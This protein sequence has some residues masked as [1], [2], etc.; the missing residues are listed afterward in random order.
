MSI[1]YKLDSNSVNSKILFTEVSN[2][3]REGFDQIGSIFS[4]DNGRA[5]FVLVLNDFLHTLLENDILTHWNV[6]C[7]LR[8][9][10]VVDMENGQ[11]RLTVSYKQRNCLNT[12]ELQYLVRVDKNTDWTID[13]SI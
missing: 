4:Q 1:E 13:F 10:K 9:N 7:D 12:T 3:I 11:Y 2:F 6:I 5:Q 8:N